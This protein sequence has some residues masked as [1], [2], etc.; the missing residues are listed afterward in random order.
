VNSTYIRMQ[1]AKIEKKFSTLL[2]MVAYY[3]TD[4]F[5]SILSLELF[6]IYSMIYTLKRYRST[7]CRIMSC[8]TIK[9]DH[10]L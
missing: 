5:F 3:D 7:L 10:M 6:D 8:N 1:G 4:Y 2:Y 9:S